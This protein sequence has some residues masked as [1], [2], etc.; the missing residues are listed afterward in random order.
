MEANSLKEH[1][2]LIICKT[3]QN[4]EAHMKI[5]QNHFF[6]ENIIKTETCT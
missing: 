5:N 3:Y 2:V 4:M 6:S 1:S